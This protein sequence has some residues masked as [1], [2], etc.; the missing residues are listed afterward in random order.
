MKESLKEVLVVT[1]KETKLPLLYLLA[2][3]T[4]INLAVC[5]PQWGFPMTLLHAP[6]FPKLTKR[7][8]KTFQCAI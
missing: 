6:C 5:T 3:A 1:I 8:V 4:A 7:E 2:V